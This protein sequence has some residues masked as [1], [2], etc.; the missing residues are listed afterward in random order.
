ML[1]P[2]I[3]EDVNS[4]EDKLNSSHFLLSKL[5]IMPVDKRPWNVKGRFTEMTKELAL[6]C[7]NDDRYLPKKT[8]AVSSIIDTINNI[9]VFSIHAANCYEVLFTFLCN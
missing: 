2:I 1:Q 8:P 7:F 6:F 3:S 4:P 9:K 5:L